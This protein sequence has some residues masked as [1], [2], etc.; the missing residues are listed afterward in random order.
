MMQQVL[1]FRLTPSRRGIRI[2]LAVAESGHSLF[3]FHKQSAVGLCNARLGIQEWHPEA[4][5]DAEA[6][7]EVFAVLED[8]LVGGIV[9]EVLDFLKVGDIYYFDV[10]RHGF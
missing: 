3:L 1:A 8:L 7:V 5:L 2:D 9:E 4:P 6:C 10:G